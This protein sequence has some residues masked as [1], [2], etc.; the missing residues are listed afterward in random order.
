MQESNEDYA[1]EA[2][3]SDDDDCFGD[4]AAGLSDEEQALLRSLLLC[5]SLAEMSEA[6]QALPPAVDRVARPRL[7]ASA[8][9]AGIFALMAA[10]K[11]AE[12]EPAASPVAPEPWISAFTSPDGEIDVGVYVGISPAPSQLSF[13]VEHLPRL[14]PAAGV[15]LLQEVG[16]WGRWLKGSC[17]RLEFACCHHPQ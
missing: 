10:E 6:L 16:I 17:C 14:I 4:E 13:L 12:A 7:I 5:T 2:G 11:A 8:A 9:L 15:R 1:E 3:P